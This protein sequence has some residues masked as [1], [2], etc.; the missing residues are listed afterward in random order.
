MWRTKY[1]FRAC[2]GICEPKRGKI[3]L[4][5]QKMYIV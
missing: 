1:G 4:E 3:E 2:C 5:M